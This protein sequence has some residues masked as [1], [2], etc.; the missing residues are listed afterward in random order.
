MDFANIK[1][2]YFGSKPILQIWYGGHLIW[3]LEDRILDET[4][5]DILQED[6]DFILI[7]EPG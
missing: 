4:G 7:D 6:S 3:A 5:F 2:A 1:S